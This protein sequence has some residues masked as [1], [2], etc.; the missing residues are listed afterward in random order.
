MPTKSPPSATKIAFSPAALSSARK[1]ATGFTCSPRLR[2]LRVD[3][4]LARRVAGGER[5]DP[6][7]PPRAVAR[8]LGQRDDEAAGVADRLDGRLAVQ[9]RVLAAAVGGDQ[10]RRAAHVLAVVEPEVAGHAGEQHAVRLAQR[11]AAR[12][13]HLQGMV[14]AEQ[15]A[16]HARQIHRHAEARDRG[17]DR[18]ASAA[19]T[20]VW[21]PSTISGCFA[22]ASAAAA[23]A[24]A[25]SAATGGATIAPTGA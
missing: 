8:A 2:G 10:R 9:A 6:L 7:R 22:R 12:V 11:V 3:L 15:A 21:L 4:G 1:N 16:R 14:A 25:A 20:T 24:T 13:A 5:G 23:R 19:S 17:G 18:G